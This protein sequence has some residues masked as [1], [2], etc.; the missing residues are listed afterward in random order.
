MGHAVVITHEVVD[1]QIHLQVTWTVSPGLWNTVRIPGQ[2]FT[3]CDGGVL[4]HGLIAMQS[5]ASRAVIIIPCRIY[6]GK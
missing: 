5:T 2:C 6:L 4:I 1:S 3:F